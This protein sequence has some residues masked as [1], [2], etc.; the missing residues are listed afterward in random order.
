MRLSPRQRPDDQKRLC[1]GGDRVGEQSI[2]RIVGQVLLTGKEAEEGSAVERNVVADGAAKHGIAGFQGVEDGLHGDRA[3][4]FELD[5]PA[6]AGKG[7]EM[8]WKDDS[9]HAREGRRGV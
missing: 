4:H 3:V 5:L 1:S 6:D 2:R 9:D 8:I 7:A